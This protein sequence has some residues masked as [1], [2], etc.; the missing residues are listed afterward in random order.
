FRKRFLRRSNCNDGLAAERHLRGALLDQAHRR[1][2]GARRDLDADAVEI[3]LAWLAEGFREMPVR[4]QQVLVER[5]AAG[6]LQRPQTDKHAVGIIDLGVAPV[7]IELVLL[8][9]A[10]AFGADRGADYIGVRIVAPAWL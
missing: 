5:P 2:R 10:R 9:L 1:F 3:G 4:Q 6:R 7:G 8:E